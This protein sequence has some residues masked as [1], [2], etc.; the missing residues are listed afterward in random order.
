MDQERNGDD[1]TPLLRRDRLDVRAMYRRLTENRYQ[2]TRP[3]PLVLDGVEGEDSWVFEGLGP[4]VIVSYDPDTEPGVE[5]VHASIA[6]GLTAR[7]PTYTDLKRLHYGVFGDGYAYQ[8][9]VPA[10][11]H[12][13]ITDNVLHLWGHLDGTPAITA[14][15]G[16]EGTI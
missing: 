7:F 8:F 11:E 12:I 13:S 16:R 15:F 9:F 1:E 10:T 2:W 14:N 3:V 4:G 5:W 6:Y